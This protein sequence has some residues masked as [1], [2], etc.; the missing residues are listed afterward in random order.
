[1]SLQPATPRRSKRPSSVHK[2][3]T[4]KVSFAMITAFT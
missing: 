2:S 3:F 4:L 1:M